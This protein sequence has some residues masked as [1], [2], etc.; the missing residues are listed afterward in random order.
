MSANA[1]LIFIAICAGEKTLAREWAACG[2]LP[3]IANL[4]K[5]GFELDTKS[6]DGLYVGSNWPSTQTACSP[7]KNRVYS[8]M[9]LQPGTYNFK[10]CEAGI[11]MQRPAFWDTLS[12][13]GKKVCVF[14]IP[15]S[16]LSKDLNG[17]Q[18][19]EWGAHDGEFGFRANSTELRED[20]IARFG[21]HPVS[22]HSDADRTPEELLAFRDELIAGAKLKG[23]FSRFYLERERP[24]FFAQVFTEAHCAGH[25]FWHLHDPDYLWHGG[26]RSPNEPDSLKM[27]Y[28]A[29]DDGV[30]ELL[31]A[32]P[33]EANVVL[34]FSH[35]MGPMYNP[36]YMVEDVLLRLGVAQE[37]HYPAAKPGLRERLD[38]FLTWGWQHTPS[39]LQAMLQP[40]RKPL[41]EWAIDDE[42]PPPRIDMPASKVFSVE[43]NHAHAGLRINLVGREPAGIVKPG[44][45]Y[46]QLLASLT[47]DFNALVNKDTGKP[48]VEAIYRTDELYVGPERDHLPDLMILWRNETAVE[49][50]SSQKIG[51]IEKPYK[52]VR[53]GE[54]NPFGLMVLNGPGISKGSLGRTV[55]VLD[56]APTLC[57]MLGVELED[58]DGE[59]IPE[60]VAL[61]GSLMESNTI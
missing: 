36:Y 58:V 50:I 34:L 14:D 10:R 29:I 52:Y 18:T 57:A 32:A 15:H 23:N 39:P 30:G 37:I 48:L 20:I 55:S 11:N 51:T 33:P 13:K 47:E 31:E 45:E 44:D 21:L 12:N 41:R 59:P 61:A 16:T 56:I 1:P 7:A 27:V 4:L 38:Q 54:H 17:L 5:N 3:N 8:W 35:G 24:D 28:Q 22:G 9:Q 19:V 46:E 40:L 26:A 60:I 2:D 49:R 53:S 25:L 42:P 6:L 43:K